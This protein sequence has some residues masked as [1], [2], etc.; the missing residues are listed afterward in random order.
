MRI[1]RYVRVLEES[2]EKTIISE[3]FKSAIIESRAFFSHPAT[4]NDPLECVVPLKINGKNIS[5]ESHYEL[6]NSYL[7][8]IL[9]E[10]DTARKKR[11]YET[12]KYGIAL[13]NCLVSCF[14]MEADNQL[15][16]SHYADQ[17]KGVCLCYEIPNTIDVLKEQI[18]WSDNI[19]Y[20]MK[21]YD[22]TFYCGAVSYR[23]ERPAMI[24]DNNI[25]Q[26]DYYFTDAVFIKPLCWH[27]EKEW[28]MVLSLPIGS[29]IG[30]GV[31]M[32]TNN[33]YATLPRNWLKE[34]SFGLRLE[35][36][37]CRDIIHLISESGY[38]EVQF[39]KAKMK[40]DRFEIISELYD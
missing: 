37:Y 25:I 16:W 35:D 23:M 17:H 7:K 4:F 13:E 2:N 22:L 32:K 3:K 39:K 31:G 33:Y 20:E 24:V 38:S 1:Y 40:H 28:R 14:S 18:K 29:E 15:M 8:T 36:E 26:N 21:K 12:I 11:I 10:S 9:N 27:Y 19:S 6:V 34:I 30:F 5:L